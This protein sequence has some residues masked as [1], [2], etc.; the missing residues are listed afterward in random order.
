VTAAGTAAVRP[1]AR[2]WY[3]LALVLLA[4]GLA[5]AITVPFLNLFLDTAVHAGPARVTLFLVVAPLSAVCVS[6]LI[7]RLSD[8]RPI[9]RPLLVVAAVAGCVGSGCTAVVRNYW[10]L[11]ALTVTATA[12]ATALLP[13]AFAYA[14]EVVQGSG[15]AAMTISSLRTLFSIAWVAGPP[16]AALL[17]DAGGFRLVDG[18]AATLYVLTALVAF[19][20]LGDPATAAAVRERPVSRQGAGPDAPRRVIV[21][22][23]AAFVLLQ[24]AGNLGVQAM[25]LFVRGDLG[26]EIRDAGL[27]LG[28]CAGLEI[29]LILAFGV[30]SARVPLRRLVPA[31]AAFGVAYFVVAATATSTWQLA[32][33]QLLNA[34]AI[35]AVQGLGVTYVQDML[36]R[37][38]GRAATLFSNAFPT[39]AMLAGPVLGAAQHFGYRTAYTAGAVLCAAGLVLLLL[40]GRPVAAHRRRW[41]HQTD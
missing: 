6:T 5:T 23:V 37:H 31:G 20:G 19:R 40:A 28:L 36:P 7:G 12:A 17:L 25:A 26:G 1:A 3:P 14:R 29:P 35:A 8:R 39:G 18:G 4:V 27:I 9:R 34:C 11:L 16:L 41:K 10:V 38:P 2:R 15:R 33:G 24:C 22:T 32:A 30:L 21:L 13:Q